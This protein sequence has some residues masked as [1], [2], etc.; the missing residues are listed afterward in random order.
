MF[1][2]D[3]KTDDA[4]MELPSFSFYEYQKELCRMVI[5]KDSIVFLPTGGGKT[6]I[7]GGV[8]FAKINELPTKKVVFVVHRVPLVKQQADALKRVMG[9]ETEVE[10]VSGPKK[11]VKSWE[12]FVRK[13]SQ[14]LVIIDSIFY[15]W[16]FECPRALAE[17]IS[18]VIIDEVHNALGGFPRKLVEM[19][20]KVR[21]CGGV[22]GSHD[23]YADRPLPQILGLTAS[24][25]RSFTQHESLTELLDITRCEIVSVSRE[26]HDLRDKVPV[27]LTIALEYVLSPPEAAFELYLRSIVQ[28]IH[29]DNKVTTHS[30]LKKLCA[31]YVAT[32]AYVNKCEQLQNAALQGTKGRHE[33]FAFTV[34]KFLSHV[35]KA[36]TALEEES[37]EQAFNL[38]M[39]KNVFDYLRKDRDAAEFLLPF[40]EGIIVVMQHLKEYYMGHTM[41]RGAEEESQNPF[42]LSS[43][44]SFLMHLLRWF[45]ESTTSAKVDV[46]GIIFCDTRASVYR[47][48][49]EINKTPLKDIY[50]PRAFVG[51]G[52]TLL[53]DEDVHMTEALQRRVLEDFRGGVTKLLV[54][55]SVAEEGLDIALCNIVIRYDSC[56]TLRSFIQS[57][58]RARSR[59]AV[60][61]VFEHMKRPFKVAKV[62]AKAV[63]IQDE[64]V[65]TAV[66]RQ[67]TL[68]MEQ[69]PWQMDPSWWLKRLEEQPWATVLR[70][71]TERGFGG[72]EGAWV[73]EFTALISGKE[74]SPIPVS[75]KYNAVGNGSLWNARRTAERMLCD[76]L[77]VAVFSSLAP[78]C[79]ENSK[80]MPLKFLSGGLCV[81]QTSTISAE[82]LR[83]KYAPEAEEVEKYSALDW[84]SQKP[85]YLLLEE[86][87]RRRLPKHEIDVDHK[88]ETCTI[89]IRV[90][91]RTSM[92]EFESKEFLEDGD[93]PLEQASLEAL[94]FLGVIF[95]KGVPSNVVQLIDVLAMRH[96][97]IGGDAA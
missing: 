35:S 33:L 45:A 46:S 96:K 1:T 8:A 9:E 44:I 69:H 42:R 73:C 23:G 87:R 56:M 31:C 61:F 89:R 24:P 2:F 16:V 51:M 20:H 79:G 97:L 27:P 3:G 57:R 19:I 62:A 58:G 13:P 60:F 81:C 74:G 54:A 49:S 14:V 65:K 66:R 59:N 53:D 68:A 95:F 77:G 5:S 6:V 50:K 55:T 82:E 4:V 76:A 40:L 15:S 22:S 28:E 71:E 29:D 26:V 85:S 30:L 90:S 18:L 72:T 67:R 92:G 41:S 94:R 91:R 25:V 80:N 88:G 12:E 21:K 37:L 75:K 32:P 63:A 17:Q 84:H 78:E 36:L 83:K 48:I 93:N 43:K 64:I 39:H 38:V 70:K 86:V 7:A 10:T 47:I 52:N 34:A 11:S